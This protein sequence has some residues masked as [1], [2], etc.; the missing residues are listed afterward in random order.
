MNIAEMRNYVRGILDIDVSDISD[1]ILNRFIGE[2]YDQVVYSEKRWTFYETETTNST[3]ANTSHYD[4]Q[5]ERA[6][7]TTRHPD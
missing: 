2:G 7:H 1:D 6:V 3:L 4:L 5:T